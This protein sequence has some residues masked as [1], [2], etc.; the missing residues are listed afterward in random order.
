MPVAAAAGL[1]SALLQQAPAQALQGAQLPGAQDARAGGPLSMG[2]SCPQDACGAAAAAGMPFSQAFG[3][4]GALSAGAA[5]GSFTQDDAAAAAAAL[6]AAAFVPGPIQGLR[7]SHQPS[8]GR[9]PML[10]GS[11]RLYGKSR[12]LPAS[13]PA[14][15]GNIWGPPVSLPGALSVSAGSGLAG[16][17]L[18]RVSA[19]AGAAAGAAAR[20]VCNALRKC[21]TG[22]PAGHSTS[23]S[24]VCLRLACVI[25]STRAGEAQLL[26]LI[27]LAVSVQCLHMEVHKLA[28]S[29]AAANA[30]ASCFTSSQGVD[31]QIAHRPPC[32]V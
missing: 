4:A 22:L 23:G 24:A 32:R 19:S 7:P 3:S 31:A 20:V 9:D 16:S 1:C 8:P 6:T 12:S 27:P 10:A 21:P 26:F 5:P 18:A 30:A 14:R 29:T 15:G 25:A 11:I 17:P 13:L 28:S 2:A